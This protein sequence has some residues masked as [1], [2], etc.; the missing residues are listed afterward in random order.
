MKINI[1]GGGNVAFHLAKAFCD[2]Q[3]DVAI[4]NHSKQSL[5][6]LNLTGVKLCTTNMRELPTDVDLIIISVK[7]RVVAEVAEKMSAIMS[8]RNIPVVHTAGSLHADILA[9]YFPNFGVLYPLQTFSKS[10]ELDYSKIPFFIEGSNRVLNTIRSVLK[11]VSTKIFV[12]GSKER[13]SLHL[14]S[15]FACN[16]VNHN[17]AIA[18][19]ILS[20]VNIP[21]NALFPLINET[22]KK[23]NYCTPVEGQTGP[24]SR[25]DYNIINKHIDMLKD[26]PT[27]QL[28]YKLETQNI[29]DY[30]NKEQHD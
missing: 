24:A 30:K 28:I 5:V 22:I 2:T 19:R 20:E 13:E 29:I 25:E 10:V 3:H 17:I 18:Q 6:S 15:V 14:A 11:N 21:I 1:L 8:N 27:E 9:P 23:L 16:F 7:D 12:L 26:F 4:W